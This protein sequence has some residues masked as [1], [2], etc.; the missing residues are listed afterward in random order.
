VLA[1]LARAWL[2]T[3]E[4]LIVGIE[5]TVARFTNTLHRNFA[6]LAL[7]GRES[8]WQY[9]DRSPKSCEAKWDHITS[10]IQNFL[11]ALRKFT[12]PTLQVYRR[13]R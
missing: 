11:G 12:L 13:I 5:K 7:K 3:S 10:D 6:L 1:N 4:D 9:E 2:T 8:T